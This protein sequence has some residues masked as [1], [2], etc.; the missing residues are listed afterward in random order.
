MLGFYLQALHGINNSVRVWYLTMEW[1]P[2]WAGHWIAFLSL[3]SMFVSLHFFYTGTILGPKFRRSVGDSI[4][5]LRA[6]S[7]YWKLSLQAP[8][9]HCWAFLVRSFPVSPGSLLHAMSLEL[10]RGFCCPLPP[11]LH[12]SIHS[13]RPLCILVCLSFLSLKEKCI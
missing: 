12:I 9:S 6:L 1:I 2:S 8:S 7:I 11:Q 13:P 3:S 10:S 4:Y 5:L